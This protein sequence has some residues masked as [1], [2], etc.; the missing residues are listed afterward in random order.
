M[1]RFRELCRPANSRDLKCHF[2]PVKSLTNMQQHLS[3]SSYQKGN[4]V[5][6]G[7]CVVFYIWWVCDDLS[8]DA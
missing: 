6:S 4:S 1:P 7:V 2:V 8:P 3:S 5:V